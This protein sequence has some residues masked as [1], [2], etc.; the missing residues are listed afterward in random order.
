MEQ[1]TCSTVSKYSHIAAYAVNKRAGLNCSCKET[2]DHLIAQFIAVNFVTNSILMSTTSFL[3][4][5]QT[6]LTV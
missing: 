5:S 2:T 3:G 1:S 4:S 6:L